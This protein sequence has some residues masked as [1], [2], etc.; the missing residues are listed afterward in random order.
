MTYSIVARDPATGHLGVAVASRFFAVGGIVPHLARR[1]RRGCDAG[2]RQPAERHRRSRHAWRGTARRTTSSRIWPNAT[3]A[4]ISASFTWSMP[5]AARP[6][7][8]ARNASTGPGTDSPKTS[9]SPATCWPGLRSSSRH[10]L[11]LSGQHGAS[12]RRTA[13]GRNAGRRGRRRRQARQAIRRLG[14]LPRSGLSL[15]QP[16]RRRSSPILWR[17]CGASLRSPRSATSTSPK[18]WPRART[19]TAWSIARRI[20]AKIIAVEKARIASG[21]PSAS[22]GTPLKVN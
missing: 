6:P 11:D 5:M 18:R 21:R 20:D 17:N 13:A 16:A 15:A 2:L 14:R 10:F 7:I 1:H 8:R 12:V 19:R 22:F 9:R 4:A 3:K